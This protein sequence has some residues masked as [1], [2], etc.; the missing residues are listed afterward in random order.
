MSGPQS[1]QTTAPTTQAGEA[2]VEKP[3]ER[4]REACPEMP[5]PAR[6]EALLMSTDRPLADERLADLLGLGPKGRAAAVG[7]AIE[8]LNGEYEQ[9]GRTFRAQRVAGGW[10]LLTLPALG[11]LVSRLH[12]DRHESRLSQPALETLAIIA[13]RQ[14]VMRA[15]IEAIRGVACGEVLRALLERRLVRIT[16]RAEQLGRP[17]LY[18]TTGHFLRTFGLPGLDALPPLEGATPAAGGI[19]AATDPAGPSE[20]TEPAEGD[21]PPE[22]ESPTEP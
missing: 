4:Q 21:D 10:Q 5:L 16:G 19:T 6:V 14:P 3:D 11:P 8:Q 1:D 2:A 12:R 17:M 22:A 7:A 15:E 9:T 20:S 18:G 13:Y